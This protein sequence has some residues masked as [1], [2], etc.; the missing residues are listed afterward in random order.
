M[1]AG[2]S[3]VIVLTITLLA[4]MLTSV[5]G[6]VWNNSACKMSVSPL[7]PTVILQPGTK[8]NATIST[9]S[10]SA[11][12]NF[13][14][15][16]PIPAYYPNN[17]NILAGTYVSGSVPSSVQTVDSDY[18]IVGSSPVTSTTA[19][20]PM[21]YNMLGS[22]A[23]VSGATA[24]L[25]SDNGAYMTFRSYV[26]SSSGTANTSAFVAYRDST[27][28]LNTPKNRTWDGT[29]WG[30]QS[31]MSTSGSPVRYART[32][33]CPV[34]QRSCEKV[35]VTLSDDGYLDAYVWDGTSWNVTNNI[36]RCWSSVPSDTRRPYDV[37]YTSG[38]QILLVYG[39]TVAGGTNDLAYRVWT[40]GSGWGT[41]QYYDDA[42]HASK[43][44]VTY[45]VC[46]SGLSN[47]TGMIY[48]ESTN[49]H[50]DAVIW[51]GSGF[52]NPI[53]LTTSV[54]VTAEEC[55]AIESETN[56]GAFVACAGEGQFVKWARFT[57]SWSSVG[58]FDIN[59]GATGSMN[60]LK[61]A[62]SQNDRLMLTS[63]DGS[64][65]LCTALLDESSIG[66]RQW[67]TRLQVQ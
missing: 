31:E 28:S 62:K 39:T 41:E 3:L 20:N 34:E 53:E 50:A 16:A 15:P 35:V 30:S 19:Y 32:A 66:N 29:A 17:Y 40:F 45:V 7:S 11:N 10:T 22:T 21:G 57:T 46:A 5:H 26:S 56:S 51:S 59:S 33:Y 44:T 1:K 25:V 23:I 6:S 9:N 58:I 37:A 36:G 47:Q 42:N 4:T 60:W 63:V 55:I 27:T 18:F 67:E 2:Y 8:G 61:L 48:L 43:I 54:A 24:D 49:S 52:G 64:T 12:V 13:A 14:A 38:G 65:D